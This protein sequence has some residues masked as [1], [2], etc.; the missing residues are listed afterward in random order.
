MIH[1]ENNKCNLEGTSFEL[2]NEAANV[3]YRLVLD[4]EKEFP[5]HGRDIFSSIAY[6]VAR[7]LCKD[8]QSVGVK[9]ICKTVE[10]LGDL[11][12]NICEAERDV[13]NQ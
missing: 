8:H 10:A 1:V 7:Q 4:Y 13:E 12:G 2:T 3:L 11:L 6:T 9:C 5:G